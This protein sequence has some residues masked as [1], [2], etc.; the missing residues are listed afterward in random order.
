MVRHLPARVA[1]MLSGQANARQLGPQVG[2]YGC[3]AAS[4]AIAA[5]RMLGRGNA[6]QLH[7]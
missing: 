2:C 1:N 4:V 3:V 6:R 5:I 7:I